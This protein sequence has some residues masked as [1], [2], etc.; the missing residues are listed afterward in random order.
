MAAAA[1]ASVSL[2]G[3]V[4]N[5]LGPSL[6]FMGA[7]YLAI[8]LFIVLTVVLSYELLSVDFGSYF[9]EVE[10]FNW[11][12]YGNNSFISMNFEFSFRSLLITQLIL[13]GSFFVILFTKFDMTDERDGISFLANMC[14]FVFFMLML[15]NSGSFIT[16]YLGWEGIGLE[17]FILIS[18]Y[19][20]R[21]RS[22]KATIKV[23][24]INKIG[25]I[26]LLIM[27][28][29][30]WTDFN[31]IQF[32]IVNSY[33][34]LLCNKTVGV[35]GVNIKISTIIAFVV[36]F[37]GSVKSAQFGWHIWLIEAMEAPMG[38]S[39][40]MHSSTLVIAGAL[41]ILKLYPIVESSPLALQCLTAWG[42][43]TAFGAPIVAT[44]AVEMKPVLANSTISNMGYIFIL[45]GSHSIDGAY[46]VILIH[47][48][49]KI[50]L[51]IVA[52]AIIHFY[53]GNQDVR[54]M[55]S[56]ILFSPLLWFGYVIGSVCLMGL[57]ATSGYLCKLALIKCCSC[58]ALTHSVLNIT[59]LIIGSLILSLF[60]PIILGYS[61]FWGSRQSH[62]SIYSTSKAI[63][64]ELVMIINFMSFLI[65]ICGLV[66]LVYISVDEFYVDVTD[67]GYFNVKIVN[68]THVY[69][70]SFHFGIYWYAGYFYL[71]TFIFLHLTE[72]TYT[73]NGR[74]FFR[75]AVLAH[76]LAIF[77][78]FFVWV[79]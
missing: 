33:V 25:D 45:L 3:L 73:D 69:Y 18:F 57:P 66:F 36:I 20:E 46:Y 5:Y 27:M 71:T 44:A 32:S 49:I 78:T 6:G 34:D 43:I 17:S 37:A 35:I 15:V 61:I 19:V 24:L 29:Y 60:Y 30:I 41:L 13:T 52:G 42:V 72:H 21:V 64:P 10:I 14:Y 62:W 76:A 23:F 22:T 40:L 58:P 2:V 59:F 75:T 53:W 47:G 26:F 8:T 1:L 70:Y 54:H 79:F 68:S 38:A 55:G 31:T 11:I 7:Y 74:Y 39:A 4:I 16:F 65:L 28:L 12:E 63:G 77:M 50:L 48:Y 51:F 56:L 9:Y 67:S